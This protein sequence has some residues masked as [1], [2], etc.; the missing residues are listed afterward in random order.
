MEK[1]LTAPIV[2][3]FESCQFEGQSL[4]VPSIFVRFFGCN[5]RCRF[6]GKNCDTPYAVLKKDK[7]CLTLTPKQL[8]DKI[9]IYNSKNI[10]F[11]GGEPMLFQTFI[12]EFI[13]ISEKKDYHYE[14][15]TNGTIY[16]LPFLQDKIHQF[17]VSLKLKSSNQERMYDS[18]RINVQTIKSFPVGKTNFKFVITN[19]KKDLKEIYGMIKHLLPNIIYLMPQGQTREEIIKNSPKVV[20]SCLQTGFYFSPREHIIIYNKK[21]GV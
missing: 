11:T 14:V 19:P 10:V 13:T 8:F 5:L 6:K 21:R 17:N 4:G 9:K 1:K 2:E 15:E 18:K 3:I 20:E 12:R 16:I 7:Y